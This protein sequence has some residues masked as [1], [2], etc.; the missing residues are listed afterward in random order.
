M[1][2]DVEKTGQENDQKRKMGKRKIDAKA[3]KK[4]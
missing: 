1:L 4:S 3:I 2:R